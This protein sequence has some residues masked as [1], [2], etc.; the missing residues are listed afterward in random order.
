[1]NEIFTHFIARED[2]LEARRRLAYAQW[3][4]DNIPLTEFDGDERLFCEYIDY[5]AKLGVPLTFKYLQVWIN[6]ELRELLH[7]TKIRVKGCETLNFDDRNSFD[8]A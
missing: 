1:M 6:T 7:A 3:F 8:T 5:S 4:T 2:K